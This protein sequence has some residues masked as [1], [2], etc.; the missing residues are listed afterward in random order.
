MGMDLGGGLW[1]NAS[2]GLPSPFWRATAPAVLARPVSAL[3][4]EAV[5]CV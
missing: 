1:W 2:Q 3:P 5:V 4:E